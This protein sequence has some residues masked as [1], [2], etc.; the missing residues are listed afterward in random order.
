MDDKKFTSIDGLLGYGFPQG[1]EQEGKTLTAL[2]N[3]ARD[4]GVISASDVGQLLTVAYPIDEDHTQFS[5]FTKGQVLYADQRYGMF[6]LE[7]LPLHPELAT[8]ITSEHLHDTEYETV[9]ALLIK[10]LL[11]RCSFDE[12]QKYVDYLTDA[13]NKPDV[14][15]VP[16]TQRVIE[17]LQET[18]DK[19][20]NDI[21]QDQRIGDA[22][23]P[24]LVPCR[25]YVFRVTVDLDVHRNDLNGGCQIT[26]K[27]A[28][29]E[30]SI[31]VASAQKSLPR[32]SDEYRKLADALYAEQRQL[33]PFFP[34]PGSILLSAYCVPNNFSLRRLRLHGNA[35]YFNNV[36]VHAPRIA[37]SFARQKQTLTCNVFI[38]GA[39]LQP[40]ELVVPDEKARKDPRIQR[41][42][43][44]LAGQR[45]HLYV[46]PDYVAFVHPK[47]KD[48]FLAAPLAV[49][50]LGSA[51]R[52][53]YR[54]VF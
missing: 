10:R 24:L 4:L 28:P 12:P 33:H 9:P 13:V 27:L 30:D 36:P 3:K 54:E 49:S 17:T 45:S 39:Y 42:Y 34:K 15:K 43:D 47:V 25:G 51:Q 19:I 1:H 20:W 6:E 48:L 38:D 35:G 41:V 37:F 11:A 22:S 40:S 44:A 52:K 7:E 23:F 26:F 16:R 5:T 8:I 18:F 29:G 32:G 46:L 14:L 31:R 53:L 2:L 21:A 50:L